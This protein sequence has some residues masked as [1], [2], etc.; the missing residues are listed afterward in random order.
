MNKQIVT[1]AAIAAG[2]WLLA[3]TGKTAV[4]A[5]QNWNTPLPVQLANDMKKSED[6][7]IWWN[8]ARPAVKDSIITSLK[9]NPVFSLPSHIVFK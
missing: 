7:G 6:Y 2:I 9:Q 4:K 5:A 1:V 3:G 8:V